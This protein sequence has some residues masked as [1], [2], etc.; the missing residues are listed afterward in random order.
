[1]SGFI[2][3]YDASVLHANPLRNLLMHLAMTDLF[4]AR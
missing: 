1:M 4:R 3:I 2:A